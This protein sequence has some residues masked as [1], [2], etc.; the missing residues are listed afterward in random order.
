MGLPDE[1]RRQSET[2]SHEERDPPVDVLEDAA[3]VYV[4]AEFQGEVNVLV[5]ATR[6]TFRGPGAPRGLLVVDLPAPIDPR[7]TTQ[8]LRNG[9]VDVVAPKAT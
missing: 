6:L 1:R 9:V 8:A 2:V 7:R 4:T 5:E 3:A